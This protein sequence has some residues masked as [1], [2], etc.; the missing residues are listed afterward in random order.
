[1]D[2]AAGLEYFLTGQRD[3]QTTALSREANR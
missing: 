3:G 2:A 1:M